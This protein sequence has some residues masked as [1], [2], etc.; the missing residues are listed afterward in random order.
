[1]RRSPFAMSAAALF[2][3]PLRIQLRLLPQMKSMP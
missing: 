3:Q 2:I 1:V